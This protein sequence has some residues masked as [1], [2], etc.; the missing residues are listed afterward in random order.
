MESR[1]ISI[2]CHNHLTEYWYDID[3]CLKDKGEFQEAQTCGNG[4][5]RVEKDDEIY[6]LCRYGDRDEIKYRCKITDTYQSLSEENDPYEHNSNGY[7]APYYFN[8]D[9]IE[10]YKDGC[11]PLEKLRELELV[12][13][14]YQ[15]NGDNVTKPLYDYIESNKKVIQDFYIKKK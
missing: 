7:V 1:I 8:A 2:Y 10:A 14:H 15:L 5:M 11:F 4:I 3:N 9:F 13:N 6:I 12:N